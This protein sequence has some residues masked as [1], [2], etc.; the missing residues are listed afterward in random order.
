MVSKVFVL[1]VI[2]C[3][4]AQA[5]ARK[6]D[7]E[8]DEDE[9]K[10]DDKS[11]EVNQS[12]DKNTS[13]ESEDEDESKEISKTVIYDEDDKIAKKKNKCKVNGKYYK[14]G[15][16]FYLHKSKCIKYKCANRKVSIYKEGCEHLGQCYKP[17]SEF[18]HGCVKYSCLRTTKADYMYFSITAQHIRRLSGQQG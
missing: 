15:E 13:D 4:L 3:L 2:A 7:E 14:D 8:D 6:V 10:D 5:A 11:E 17:N 9:S 1:G 16:T 18:E 12:K